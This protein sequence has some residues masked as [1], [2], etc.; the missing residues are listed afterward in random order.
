MPITVKYGAGV[1]LADGLQV[2]QDRRTRRRAARVAPKVR[3]GRVGRLIGHEFIR[4]M[5]FA[6]CV[7]VSG[8]FE[9]VRWNVFDNGHD[10]TL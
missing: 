5:R 3:E 7:R 8:T 1:D 4:S 2:V 10:L 6:F 9:M